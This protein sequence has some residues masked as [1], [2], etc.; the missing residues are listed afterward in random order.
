[1]QLRGDALR[2]V[3]AQGVP[4]VIE[5]TGRSMEPTIA[6]HA[7]VSVVGLAEHEAPAAG[8]IVLL[9]TAEADV[10]L[11]HR[12]LV[13]FE[14]QGDRFVLHQGDAPGSIFGICARRDVLGRMTGFADDGAPAAARPAPTPDQLDADARARFRRRRAAAEAYVRARGV[15][16]ALGVADSTLVRRC[17]RVFRRLAGALAR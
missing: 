7:K 17:G 4:A 6:L 13:V 14:D 10:R 9:A 12:V 3:L 8:E 11:L 15:A 16:R 5:V 2:F 1:M